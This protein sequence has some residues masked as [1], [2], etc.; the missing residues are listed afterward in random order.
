[1]N[2]IQAIKAQ[3]RCCYTRRSDLA[4][5]GVNAN[6]Q[7][8]CYITSPEMVHLEENTVIR[9]G[10][11]ILNNHNE[12]LY[13]K[14]Y[15]VISTNCT[16][17]TNNHKSTVG[18]PQCLLGA[19]HV[20]D[21]SR[22][23]TIGEDVFVGTNVTIMSGGDIGRGCVIGACS[24]VTKP[25]PPYAIAVGS[26][27]HVVGV[28]FTIDQILKHEEI[29]YP[30]EERISRKELDVLFEKYYKGMKPYGVD[31]PLTEKDLAGLEW[32]IKKRHFVQPKH[33]PI[34]FRTD[35]QVR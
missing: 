8:P 19:S 25:I 2:I 33:A 6:I 4:S 21:I 32:A 22:D 15:T 16:I 17:V 24:L 30:P 34:V 1:M 7:K 29:L 12:H 5:A 13:I 31:A 27:A 3:L 18:I 9:R 20:N 28:K 14:K 10:S 23:L 26:P 35:K 11:T